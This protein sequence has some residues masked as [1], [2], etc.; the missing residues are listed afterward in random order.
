MDVV[1]LEVDLKMQVF[2]TGCSLSYSLNKASYPRA[3]ILTSL[4][5][6]TM[7][8]NINISLVLG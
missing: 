5:C 4:T 1:E 2:R 7:C 3:S 8:K 6:D